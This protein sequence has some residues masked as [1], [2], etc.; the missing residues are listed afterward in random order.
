MQDQK[1]MTSAK[2]AE[3]RKKTGFFKTKK[4]KRV[5]QIAV[6]LLVVAGIV[7]GCMA[8]ARKKLNTQIGGSYLVSQAARQ[9]ITVTVSESG[10]LEPADSYHVTT[11]LSGEIQ[12]APF[13]IGDLVTKDTLLYALDSSDAQSN[14]NR[15]GLSVEQAQLGLTQ[16]KEA[17]NP[18]A[19]ING[20][21]REVL[22]KNGDNVS[23]G[24]PIA[25]LTSSMDLSIDFLFPYVQP[26]EFYIGQPATLFINGVA[27]TT[28]GKVVAVSDATTVTSNGKEGCSVRVSI[29]NPGVLSDGFTA[30]AVIGS[31]SS[32]GDSPLSASGTSVVYASGSGT[33]TGFDKLAGSEVKVG[34]VLCTIESDSTRNQVQNAKLNLESARLS[35]S[36]TADALDDYRIKSPIAGTVIEKNFKTGDKVDASSGDLA[37]I[38]DLS[39]LKLE[40]AVHELDIA[41][42]QVGQKVEIKADAVEGQTFT[43]VVDRIS[44][45]GTNSGGATSYPVTIIVEDY[46]DLKPGMTVSASILGE[47]ASDVLCIPVDAVDRGNI[48]HV[49]GPG[50]M[51]E[52]GTTVVDPSKVET[53]EV[54]LGLNDEVFIEVL[55]GLEEGDIVLTPNQASSMMDLMTMGA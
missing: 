43:G 49:P 17:L 31:Y 50:A 47:T 45:N 3:A 20:I 11:L 14:V 55:D 42:V 48:V 16:A 54:R 1:E 13:E 46:G 18:T 6:V 38:F 8:G 27:G 40:M 28:A 41:K 30:S 52:D 34:E 19:T 26:E 21:I 25:K 35:A 5:L 9:D 29:P 53:R 22:V 15:A 12:D 44:I 2:T 23:P 10:T 36:S 32:Y 51:S 24:T 7:A 4:G 39:Y 37:V 33:V